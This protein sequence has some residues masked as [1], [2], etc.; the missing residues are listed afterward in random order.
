MNTPPSKPKQLIV[1]RAPKKL[2]PIKNENKYKTI[3]PLKLS[4]CPSCCGETLNQKNKK[5]LCKKCKENICL[6]CGEEE[7]SVKEYCKSCFNIEC[8]KICK[9]Y[10]GNI[11]CSDCK[12][13]LF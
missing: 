8:C 7:K 1:P 11:V 2:S 4:F 10:C 9:I 6:N 13:E 3:I 12:H 5:Y